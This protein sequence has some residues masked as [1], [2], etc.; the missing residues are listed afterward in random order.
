MDA[1]WFDANVFEV[2]VHVDDLPA[3]LRAV[4]T[5]EPLHRPAG[6]PMGALA[7]AVVSWDEAGAWTRD[8]VAYPGL[9]R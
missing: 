8:R 2:A 6:D 1:A 5:E 9:V 3:D 7:C 4:I